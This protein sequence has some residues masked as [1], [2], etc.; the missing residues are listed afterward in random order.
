MNAPENI[1]PINAAHGVLQKAKDALCVAD[2]ARAMDA[3][4]P[5][6]SRQLKELYGL[7]LI[8]MEPHAGGTPFYRL[9]ADPKAIAPDVA[10][11]MAEPLTLPRRPRCSI[12]RPRTTR[13]HRL[14][15]N[16]WRWRIG[17]FRNSLTNTAA[18]SPTSRPPHTTT[19]PT[20][21]TSRQP[22]PSRSWTCSLRRRGADRVP[23]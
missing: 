19:C 3:S 6:A 22:V 1:T 14:I 4:K 16:C 8:E 23:V 13:C 12:S 17:R 11:G 20:R 5:T 10:A 18:N 7:G 15:P 2:V 21:A 9:I